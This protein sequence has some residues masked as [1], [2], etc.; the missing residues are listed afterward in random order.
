AV[1]AIL[2][3]ASSMLTRVTVARDHVR[4]GLQL[5]GAPVLEGQ[6]ERDQRLGALQALLED[7]RA[8]NTVGKLNNLAVE[9]PTIDAAKAGAGELDAVEAAS[10]AHGKLSDVATY[11]REAID[12]FGPDFDP[13]KDAADLRMR[14]LDLFRIGGAGDV[15]RVTELRA[16]ADRLRET[17]AD[18]AERAL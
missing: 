10:A 8:R 2:Q 18:A 15:T 16:E 13:S 1:T 14:M 7:V 11:L 12:V 4:D 17:F 6:Q 9:G 3:S 5:W